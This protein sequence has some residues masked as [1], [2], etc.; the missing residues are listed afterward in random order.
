MKKFI[1][2]MEVTDDIT[3]EK[4]HEAICRSA[5]EGVGIGNQEGDGITVIDVQVVGEIEHR[6]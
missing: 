5:H 6:G 3:S 1:V 2:V 4:L